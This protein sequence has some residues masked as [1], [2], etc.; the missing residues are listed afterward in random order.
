MLNWKPIIVDPPADLQ[1]TKPLQQI[2]RASLDVSSPGWQVQETSKSN[3]A[4]QDAS[5]ERLRHLTSLCLKR[6]GPHGDLPP[7]VAT[8]GPG[9]HE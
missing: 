4:N 6:S 1:E 3:K 2:A 5:D 8:S 7:D 9:I